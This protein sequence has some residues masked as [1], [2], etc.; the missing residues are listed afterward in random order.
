MEN[1][2]EQQIETTFN[3]IMNER[4]VGNRLGISRDDVYN[5]KRRPNLKNMLYVLFLAEKL[6]LNG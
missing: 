5:Y 4:G 6:K 2:T 3:Q 1:L